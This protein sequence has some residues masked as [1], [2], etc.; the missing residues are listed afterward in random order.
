MGPQGLL[1]LTGVKKSQNSPARCAGGVWANVLCE[2]HRW[3]TWAMG[4]PRPSVSH[5]LLNNVCVYIYIYIFT[6]KEL[7]SRNRLTDMENALVVT[8]G[9]GGGEFRRFG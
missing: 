5:S 7:T 9:K 4:Y 3:E 8:K 2:G 1:M 6:T